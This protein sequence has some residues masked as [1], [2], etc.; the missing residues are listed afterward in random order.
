M[1]TAAIK[2]C[3][4]CDQHLG[5]KGGHYTLSCMTGDSLIDP[6]PVKVDG[7]DGVDLCSRC[8]ESLFTWWTHYRRAAAKE[9]A[10]Q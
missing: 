10:S 2:V 5:T 7:E 4:R 9:E 1:A 3:D 6:G 8:E